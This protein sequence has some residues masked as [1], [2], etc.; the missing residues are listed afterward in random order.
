M[1]TTINQREI[2]KTITKTKIREDYTKKYA[3]VNWNVVFN[4]FKKWKVILEAAKS[5]LDLRWILKL[6]RYSAEM[7]D[8]EKFYE[9]GLALWQDKHHQN[10]F[11]IL[12]SL[13]LDLVAGPMSLRRACIFSVRWYVYRQQ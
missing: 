10:S 3:I 11:A 8:G 5:A 9:T 13:A 6:D 4:Y 2:K 7:S 1:T 12:A